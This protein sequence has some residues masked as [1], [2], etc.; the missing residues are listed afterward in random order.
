LRAQRE[1]FRSTILPRT[2][3]FN[4]ITEGH[5]ERPTQMGSSTRRK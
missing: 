2:E 5:W 3:L 1:K 4:M